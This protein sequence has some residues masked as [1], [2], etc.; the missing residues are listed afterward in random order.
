MYS[1]IFGTECH[2][3]PAP[4]IFL[5]PSLLFPSSLPSYS[6][7]PSCIFICSYFAQDNL[8]VPTH[9][10]GELVLLLEDSASVS[11]SLWSPS[12]TTSSHH[13]LQNWMPLSL[14]SITLCK[15]LNFSACL[16]VF[17]LC[18]SLQG[19]SWQGSCV[20]HCCVPGTGHCCVMGEWVKQSGPGMVY[21][22]S[23]PT[24]FQPCSHGEWVEIWVRSIHAMIVSTCLRWR[25]KNNFP[26]GNNSPGASVFCPDA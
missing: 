18:P 15:S 22:P 23:I 13:P 17:W 26:K 25:D 2:V 9:K 11:F 20:L 24:L 4:I 5:L 10:S 19:S 14:H 7:F 3:V 16:T 1:V 21:Y 8:S 6:V 12:Q